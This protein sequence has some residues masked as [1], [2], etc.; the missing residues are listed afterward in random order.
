MKAID[1]NYSIPAD[2]SK[3]Y[4]YLKCAHKN[5]EGK[6]DKIKDKDRD[7]TDKSKWVLDHGQNPK[8]ALFKNFLDIH[9]Q[10]FDI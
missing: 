9:L 5:G 7:F 1:P 6:N 8:L 3:I 4:V 2:K 10:P